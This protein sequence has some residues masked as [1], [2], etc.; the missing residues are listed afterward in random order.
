MRRACGVKGRVV[1]AA[2]RL[3]TGASGCIV[4]LSVYSLLLDVDLLVQGL[5][6]WNP[7]TGGVAVFVAQHA[8]RT[9]AFV[10]AARHVH[11]V[12]LPLLMSAALGLALQPAKWPAQAEAASDP[13]LA[14]LPSACHGAQPQQWRRRWQAHQQ[15]LSQP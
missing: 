14:S 4:Y 9:C 13:G 5:W 11:V 1:A 10:V 6:W 12:L 15:L 7:L 3:S 8:V 2:R